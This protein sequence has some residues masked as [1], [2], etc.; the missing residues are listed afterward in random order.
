MFLLMEIDFEN[1]LDFFC[2]KLIRNGIC[3]GFIYLFYLFC[4]FIFLFQRGFSVGL[5]LGIRLLI[6]CHLLRSTILRV[7]D[8]S[9]VT[10][11]R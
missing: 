6:D 8:N 2:P 3:F 9:I 7:L 11:N 10:Q 1:F 4:L 5:H